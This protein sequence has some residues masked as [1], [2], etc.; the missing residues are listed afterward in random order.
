MLEGGRLLSV[1]EGGGD[2]DAGDVAHVLAASEEEV[3]RMKRTVV[4]KKAS[5]TSSRARKREREQIETQVQ[6]QVQGA[7]GSATL[8][9]PAVLARLAGDPSSFLGSTRALRH[10]AFRRC[11]ADPSAC[12][13]CVRTKSWP[14]GVRCRCRCEHHLS[15]LVLSRPVHTR[16]DGFRGSGP[17]QTKCCSACPPPPGNETGEERRRIP[18]DLRA[19]VF[20][21]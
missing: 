9:W 17:G 11:A 13:A 4:K 18:L 7:G 5:L 12:A 3:V 20:A 6:V 1:E 15:S 16:P 2:D 19:R 10:A 8:V 21:P 14:G